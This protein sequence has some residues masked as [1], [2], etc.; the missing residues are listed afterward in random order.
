MRL[1]VFRVGLSLFF[2]AITGLF[3]QEYRGSLSGRVVDPGGGVVP[4]ALV[5]VMNTATNVRLTTETNA[6]GNY[7]ISLLQPGSY[8]LRVERAGF[9]AFERSPIEVRINQVVQVDAELAIGSTTETVNVQAETPLL[10]LGSA[11]VRA[12]AQDSH[13]ADARGV[14]GCTCSPNG[15]YVVEKRPAV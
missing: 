8:S 15:Q 10:D 7:T 2:L 3:A 13:G 6:Q 11:S 12:Y 14:P 1:R 4:G 9:K 5:T